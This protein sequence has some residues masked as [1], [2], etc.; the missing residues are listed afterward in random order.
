[1]LKLVNEYLSDDP[2]FTSLAK[3]HGMS[4]SSI[5]Q[6]WVRLY[7][8]YGKKGLKEPEIQSVFPV[9]FKLDVLR[10]RE[11]TGLSY[12]KTADAFGIRF[13]SIVREWH[14]KVQTDGMEALTET[15]GRAPMA[16]IER[17]KKEKDKL[18]KQKLKDFDAK[19]FAE[20]ERENELLRLE[21]AY[22]KKL[23]TFQDKRL[24]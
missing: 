12:Q 9:Q 22:L 24:P 14:I 4:S 18:K 3:K 2:T 21:L 17:R 8:Q 15:K 13:G 6:T 19:R 20:L 16:E 23:E 11:R 7:E 1:K 10:Y 5:I